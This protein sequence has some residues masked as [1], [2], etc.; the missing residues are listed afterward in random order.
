MMAFRK[1]KHMLCGY[2]FFLYVCK[3]EHL[4]E[5]LELRTP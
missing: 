2:R 4:K 1:I 5:D 3:V